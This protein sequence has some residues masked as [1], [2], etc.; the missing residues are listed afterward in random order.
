LKGGSRRGAIV[1]IRGE[2]AKAVLR[3]RRDVTGWITGEYLLVGGA[4]W[5]DTLEGREVFAA[6]VVR[7][8]GLGG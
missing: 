2:D 8:G 1:V 5:S 4:R 3:V 6:P 7:L